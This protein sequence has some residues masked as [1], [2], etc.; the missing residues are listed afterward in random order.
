MT[1]A[2]RIDDNGE[3]FYVPDF[4]VILGPRKMPQDVVLDVTQVSFKNSLTEM[5]S[6]E[7]TLTNLWDHA[8]G[9]F[10]YSDASLFDPGQT[11]TLS[12]GYLG[13]TGLIPMITGEITGPV[14]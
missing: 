6:F 4:E 1:A 3:D 9:L 13:R 11:V 2:A 7:L 10:K 14:S 5:D 8:T 12:M